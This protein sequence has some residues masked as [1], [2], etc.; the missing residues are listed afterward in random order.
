ML[1]DLVIL[2][3]RGAGLAGGV[4]LVPVGWMPGWLSA[5]IIAIVTGVAMLWVYK[6]TSNQAAIRR[7]RDSIKANLLALALFRD[8]IRV[9]LRCQG[10]ILLG[11]ARLVL[12]SLVP[13][14]VMA[15]PACLV[16]G[17]LALRYQARPLAVGE[18]AVVT[19][20]LANST[21]SELPD[22]RLETGPAVACV[23]GP[24]RVPAK[25]TVAW[26][27]K[28][29]EEGYHDL[30]FEIEGR[31]SVKQIAAGGGYM[32]VSLK[33][34]ERS[35]TEVLLHPHEEPFGRD[36]PIMSIEVAYPTRQSWTSGT[37]WWVGYWF[38]VSMAAAF[39]ARP[40]LKVN[41]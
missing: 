9:A 29:L 21:G 16:L 39:A 28:A 17:Q 5:T 10:S 38:V 18:E 26:N 22:V 37:D 19:V 35:L 30:S 31:A 4:L 24:V 32:T 7:T 36:S 12:L 33:R 40:L 6:H 20:G 11:A 13:V 34:P 2:L 25:R 3:N 41:L 15:L 23:A 8:E 14:L 1:T 27:V